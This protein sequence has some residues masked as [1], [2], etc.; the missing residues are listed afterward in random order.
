M[1]FNPGDSVH[2]IE[3]ETRAKVLEFNHRQDGNVED[4]LLRWIIGIVKSY[5]RLV[6]TLERLR[7]SYGALLVETHASGSNQLLFEVE[8]VLSEARRARSLVMQGSS[9]ER[10]GA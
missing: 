2:P 8:S 5:E 6:T 3:E 1:P 10:F 4:Q 9:P 7:E